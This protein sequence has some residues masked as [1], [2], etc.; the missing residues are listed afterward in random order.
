[1]GKKGHHLPPDA[2]LR[3]EGL[4]PG[5]LHVPAVEDAV[6]VLLG[7]GGGLRQVLERRVG[8]Q[9]L[10]ELVGR[11]ARAFHRLRRTRA[12]TAAAAALRVQ[13]R[14]LLDDQPLQGH[15]GVGPAEHVALDRVRSREPEDEHGPLLADAVAAVHGLEVVVRVPVRVVDDDGI[16]GGQVDA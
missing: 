14:A 2:L 13:E 12:R 4:T 5:D 9:Q 16:R 6:E 7:H 10:K 8:F 15:L 11:H 3:V 1:M